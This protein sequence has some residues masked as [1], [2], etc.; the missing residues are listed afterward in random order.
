MVNIDLEVNFG[1]SYCILTEFTIKNEINVHILTVFVKTRC[2]PKTKT[3]VYK[4]HMLVTPWGFKPHKG[5]SKRIVTLQREPTIDELHKDT[6]QHR[7]K[8]NK[9][10]VYG[11][12]AEGVVMKQQSHLSVSTH[13]SSVNNYVVHEMAKTLNES[14]SKVVKEARQEEFHKQV[15]EEVRAKLILEF[16]NRW[17]EKEAKIQYHLAQEKATRQRDKKKVK[18]KKNKMWRFFKS[19]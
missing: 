17:V 10:C 7:M 4:H 14:A 5:V 15:E 18:S 8:D 19:Q 11:F 6:H 12:V 3:K 9:R 2:Q 16:K 13:S 1:R